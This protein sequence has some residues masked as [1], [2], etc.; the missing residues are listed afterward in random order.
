MAER[1][2]QNL[3]DKMLSAV[4]VLKDVGG[5]E[6]FNM[7]RIKNAEQFSQ[8]FDEMLAALHLQLSNN[9][10][11]IDDITNRHQT[12]SNGWTTKKDRLLASHNQAMR[13]YDLIKDQENIIARIESRGHLYALFFRIL[14]TLG[15]GMAVMGIYGL[16]DIWGVDMPLMRASASGLMN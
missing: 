1:P 5:G 7:T 13:A 3:S 2:H 9:S 12:V 11:E 16:A 14:T 15:I 6:I 4:K 10:G 8:E